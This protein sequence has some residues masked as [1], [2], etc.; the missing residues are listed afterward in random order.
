MRPTSF[1]LRLSDPFKLLGLSKSCT[2]S[3]ARA[4]YYALAKT[5]HPDASPSLPSSPPSS[6]TPSPRSHFG[7]LSDA[8]RAVLS[9]LA[10]PPS[11]TSR[12]VSNPAG[13]E[14]DDYG[15]LLMQMRRDF[16]GGRNKAVG[17]PTRACIRAG[18]NG[19]PPCFFI[20]SAC[21]ALE[22]RGVG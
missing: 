4:A 8:Y 17:R 13:W 20:C 21:E 2:R 16:A 14:E 22:K 11:A 1:L 18:V 3:E 10:S 6:S 15:A 7:D 12:R 9:H 5:S 19:E